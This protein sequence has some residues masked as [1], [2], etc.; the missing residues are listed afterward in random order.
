MI[1]TKKKKKNLLYKLIFKKKKKKKNLLYKLLFNKKQ[2]S[3]LIKFSI[4]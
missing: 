3:F 2:Y 4:K 1:L